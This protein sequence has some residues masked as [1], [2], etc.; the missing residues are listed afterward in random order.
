MNRVLRIVSV[1]V[2]V[3]LM[4]GAANAQVVRIGITATYLFDPSATPPS[5]LVS[6]GS[7]ICPGGFEPTGNIIFP[8]PPGSRTTLRGLT[9]MAR[10]TGNGENGQLMTGWNL[11]EENANYDANLTGRLWGKFTLTLDAGGVWEGVFTG[12]R[13]FENGQP[14]ETFRIV[15]HGSGGLVDGMQLKMTMVNTFPTPF[16]IAGAIQGTILQVPR[17]E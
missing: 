14:K 8:C 1:F 6:P 12:V 7:V 3:L 11:I 5:I 17:A 15:G 9:V 13:T 16:T 10:V 2:L 4:M